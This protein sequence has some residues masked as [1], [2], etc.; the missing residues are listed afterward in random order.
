MKWQFVIA[1]ALLSVLAAQ[2]QIKLEPFTSKACGFSI[3]MP[4]TP[5]EQAMKVKS[6]RGELESK[7]FGLGTDNKVHWMVVVVDYPPD[8]PAELA[9]A[10]LDGAV[11]GT[12]K[13]LGGKTL[14]EGKITLDNKYPGRQFQVESEKVGIHRAHVFLVGN[15]LYQIVVR[16]PKEGVTSPEAK[17]YLESFKLLD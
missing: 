4:G 12:A 15:R 7:T 16:G 5:K 1:G 6:D 3:L 10:L 2:A 14:S 8:T 9:D 11:K 13:G 17:K